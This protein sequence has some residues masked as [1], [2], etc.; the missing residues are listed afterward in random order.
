MTSPRSSLAV[1]ALV[2]LVVGSVPAA[3]Q[4]DDGTAA[5]AAGASL[6]P[7]TLSWAACGAT[8]EATAAGVECAKAGL[9]MDYDQ[10]DGEQV[11]IAVARVPA[12]DPAQ[13]IG[14]LFF[15]FGGPGGPAVDYLQGSG[16]GIFAALNQRFD[17]IAV[18]PRGVGQSTP[19]VDCQVDDETHG[20]SP[21]PWP[22]PV[23]VDP[24]ALVAQAQGYVDAC[25]ATN[26]SILE[27]LS[28]ANVARDFD[29]IREALGEEKLNYLGFSYGTFLGATYASLFPDRYRAM[30]LDSALD[31]DQWIND[32]TSGSTAQLAS[33]ENS[34]D[35][36]LTACGKD[37]AACSG[38]GDGDPSAAYDR[39]LAKA[40]ETPI[41][42][43][44]YPQDPR[45]VTADDIRRTTTVL[46]YSKSFWGLLAAGLAQAEAGDASVVRALV[47]LVVFPQNDA[48]PDRF[49][50]IS[51]SEQK[52]PTDV[53][54]Y[55]QRGAE[56]WAAYPHFWGGFAY[57]EIAWG[58]W[59]VHDEDA[60]GGPFVA[61]SDASPVLVVNSTNDPATPY[62]GAVALTQQL[63]N[64]VL[65]TMDGDGHGAYGGN[66]ACI[67]SATDS[68]LVAGTLPA[69]GTVCQQETPFQA[70]A[71]VPAATATARAVETALTLVGGS[72]S[73]VR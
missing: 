24:D 22:T 12:T 3:A 45:P 53:D 71:Q 21:N 57:S 46:L 72:A 59:P 67:D 10:P 66:S 58:L 40:A 7:V 15:N 14:S 19:A 70:P 63:G 39:L 27:H 33:F 52:W 23:D 30:V 50:A 20:Y 73:V 9:P 55:L 49:F 25:L 26:G 2:A 35:R 47:D 8:P 37:Q 1:G 11:Q 17:I 60:F 41:A 32:P 29:A 54:S 65:L 43:P 28:T 69:A 36:F 38:F 61:S 5:P 4:A 68:Y 48:A 56:E 13:R 34:L 31:P 62:D 18:D 64:A 16:A 42:A 6:A 51:A 44:N